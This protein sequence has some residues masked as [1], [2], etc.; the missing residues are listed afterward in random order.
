MAPHYLMHLIRSVAPKSSTMYLLS[1]PRKC[2]VAKGTSILHPN[3][4]HTKLHANTTVTFVSTARVQRPQNALQTHDA[5]AN[6][7][8]A[9]PVRRPVFLSTF[10]ERLDNRQKRK[11]TLSGKLANCS[12]TMGAAIWTGRRCKF[13]AKTFFSLL[14]LSSSFFFPPFIFI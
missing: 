12:S 2:N 4:L 10:P 8:V 6:G 9:V 13:G 1:V 3:P 11:P 14:L 5:K 7:S